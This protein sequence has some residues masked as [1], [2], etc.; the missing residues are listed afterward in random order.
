MTQVIL[1]TEARL[2]ELIK[3]AIRPLTEA[4]S[5]DG[6]TGG[7]AEQEWLSN[8]DARLMLGLSRST[9]QRYRSEGKLPYV[10]FYGNIRY[11]RSD[12]EDLLLNNLRIPG[13]EVSSESK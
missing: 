10:K 5:N 9:L 8:S 12:L 13:G 7:A 2:Q 6:E 4:A 1:T 3:D 11:R